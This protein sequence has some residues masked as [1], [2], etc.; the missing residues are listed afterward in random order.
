MLVQIMM[1]ITTMSAILKTHNSKCGKRVWSCAKAAG[2]DQDRSS[3]QCCNYKVV[4]PICIMMTLEIVVKVVMTM[5]STMCQLNRLV[6][7]S[8]TSEGADTVTVNLVLSHRI[9]GSF[10]Q[11]MI[12]H[13]VVN[14]ILELYKGMSSHKT[15]K[16]ALETFIAP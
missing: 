10:Y 16:E 4:L 11:I 6:E 5:M 15:R 13:V 1:T 3:P 9:L 12:W 14:E 2:D 7:D 8:F